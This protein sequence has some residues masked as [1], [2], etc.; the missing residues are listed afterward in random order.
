MRY[1]NFFVGKVKLS[2]VCGFIAEETM[3]ELV[4]QKMRICSL[5]LV[6]NYKINI[7]WVILVIG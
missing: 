7:E 5:L 6:V 3:K 4:R 2:V 1:P